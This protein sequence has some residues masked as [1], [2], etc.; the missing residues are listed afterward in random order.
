[1]SSS[2]LVFSS[3]LCVRVL[4]GPVQFSNLV[5]KADVCFDTF[6][7]HTL[8]TTIAA[9]AAKLPEP[10]GHGKQLGMHRERQ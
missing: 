1:M 2:K 3:V 6:M 5:Q 7:V 8:H 9:L 10:H 4:L